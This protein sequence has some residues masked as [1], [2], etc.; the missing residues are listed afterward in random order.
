MAD[1]QRI[2]EALSTNTV[3]AALGWPC[4][5]ESKSWAENVLLFAF[6]ADIVDVFLYQN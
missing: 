3:I 4:L 1:E 2:S 6:Q 5:K